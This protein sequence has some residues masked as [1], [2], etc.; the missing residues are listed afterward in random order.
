MAPHGEKGSLTNPPG[1]P[2]SLTEARDTTSRIPP[3]FHRTEAEFR[4]AQLEGDGSLRVCKEQRLLRKRAK[5]VQR[6]GRE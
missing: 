1:A 3:C 5:H 2:P 6:R 4:A